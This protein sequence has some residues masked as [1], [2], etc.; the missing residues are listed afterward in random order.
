MVHSIPAAR[1]VAK[2]A[3]DSNPPVRKKKQRGE[4]FLQ[5]EKNIESF[6]ALLN[7]EGYEEGTDTE[8][9]MT[10]LPTTKKHFDLSVAVMDDLI[11]CLWSAPNGKWAKLLSPIVNPFRLDRNSPTEIPAFFDV[12]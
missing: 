9:A 2:L 1:A 3:R 11:H 4:E 5:S 12:F 8:I 6:L 10:C 7:E